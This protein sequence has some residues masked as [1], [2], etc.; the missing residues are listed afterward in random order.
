MFNFL[1]HRNSLKRL[2]HSALFENLKDAVLVLDP[3]DLII[4]LNKEAVLLFETTKSEIIGNH[5][6]SLLPEWKIIH[7]SLVNNKTPHELVEIPLNIKEQTQYYNADLSYLHDKQGKIISQ[8]I[9]LRN[10][11]SLHQRTIELETLL[12]GMMATSSSL[13]LD[14]V[15]LNLARQLVKIGEFQ[16]CKIYEWDEQNKNIHTLVEH[17]RATWDPNGKR[18]ILVSDDSTTEHVIS[19]GQPR[20]IHIHYDD[21]K[22]NW[23]RELGLVSM[24][25]LPIRSGDMIVG[26]VEIGSTNYSIF[27]KDKEQKICENLLFNSSIWI[28][29]P[30]EKN[31]PAELLE[32]LNQL[33]NISGGTIGTISAWDLTTNKLDTLIEYSDATWPKDSSPKIAHE[34]WPKVLDLLE[35]RKAKVLTVDNPSNDQKDQVELLQRGAKTIVILPICIKGHPIGLLS[36][37]DIYNKRIINSDKMQLWRGLADQAALAIENARLYSQ[38]QQEIQE[39]KHA[40]EQLEQVAY[41]DSLT[42]LPNRAFFLELVWN[43]I[44]RQRRQPEIQFAVLYMDLD[45]F[46]RVNDSLGHSIGDKLL[47]DVANRLKGCIRKSDTI[48]RLGGDEFVILI[49]QV[50]DIH[51]V[52]RISNRILSSLA[53]QF[54][55]SGHEIITTCSIGIVL[56]NIF[57]NQP[58]EILRDADIAMYRAKDMGKS[59]FEFFDQTMR[60]KIVERLKLE[61]DLSRA[62]DCQEFILHY[63]PIYCLDS[64]MTIGFE[65]LIRWDSPDRGLVQPLDFI[66]IAEETG[67][68]V[69]IG[70]WVLIEACHQLK[71][72]QERF[73]F[74]QSLVMSINISGVQL[75]QDDFV[76]MVKN[77]LSKT[78]ISPSSLRLEVTESAVVEDI[79]DAI[80]KLKQ[81]REHGICIQLDDFGKGYSSFGYLRNLPMD[82]I[83]IDQSFILDL[84]QTK[85]QGLVRTM[86]SLGNEWGMDVIAEGIETNEQNSYLEQFGCRYGQGFLYSKPLLPKQI[87][88]NL[89]AANDNSK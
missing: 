26:L 80:N 36:L 59:R 17:A 41:H 55:I 58:D 33:L 37:Y 77:T 70:K 42:S 29:T 88:G 49:D 73:P 31:D 83:K 57:Y 43:A 44:W 34:E 79:P 11:S 30:L 16:I 65:A 78:K 72:W 50:K 81:L 7:N 62:I 15:L 2:S 53:K 56:G 23:M 1:K 6:S 19:T 18:T 45:N 48:A 84:N 9:V 68:I 24:M 12:E 69:D 40:E 4:D 21:P 51:Q 75:F 27:F 14:Q 46:K 86:I 87:E 8:V 25:T 89:F 22:V 20:I 52:T 85:N 5:I 35:N 60:I 38:A 10:I 3:S 82:V 28:K 71:D 13:D 76:T 67:K 47:I 64:K 32:L 61:D 66:P 54:N 63:Q 39:R 74:I